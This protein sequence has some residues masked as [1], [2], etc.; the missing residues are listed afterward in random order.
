MHLNIENDEARRLATELAEIT[1]ESLTEAVIEAL[2]ER[3]ERERSIKERKQRIDAITYEFLDALMASGQPMTQKQMDE[4][5]YD[6]YGL[7][8]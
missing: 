2:R 1:G 8:R 5:M 7:P 3:L 4:W 6:E